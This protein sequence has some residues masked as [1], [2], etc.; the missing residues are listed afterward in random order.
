M[1]VSRIYWFRTNILHLWYCIIFWHLS[2][3]GYNNSQSSRYLTVQADY[4]KYQTY[5][6]A[7]LI[8]EYIITRDKCATVCDISYL[9]GQ[10]CVKYLSI[11]L[12]INFCSLLWSQM[13]CLPL[14]RCEKILLPA[15]PWCIGYCGRRF[16][17]WSEGCAHF[18]RLQLF[19]PH[20]L[21]G[22][23]TLCFSLGTS[24]ILID[25]LYL[26]QGP[27]ASEDW[28]KYIFNSEDLSPLPDSFDKLKACKLKAS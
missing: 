1:I 3:Y 8:T 18:S 20:S 5:L 6:I 21:L 25:Q 14:W 19:K 2:G 15:Q 11:K 10:R 12:S 16:S 23:V 22:F 24:T 7:P 17:K 9:N 26:D 28:I 27:T 13:Q 4:D